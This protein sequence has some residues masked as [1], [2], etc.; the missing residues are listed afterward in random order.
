[1]GGGGGSV[2][3]MKNFGGPLFYDKFEQ[4]H[5]YVLKASRLTKT[6]QYKV[7]HFHIQL[8]HVLGHKL[9]LLAAVMTSKMNLDIPL[10]QIF[11]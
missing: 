2:W 8:H 10:A 1:M 7:G 6:L 11:S 4:I 9:Y 3:L 5:Q